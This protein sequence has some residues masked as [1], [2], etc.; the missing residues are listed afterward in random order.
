MN[1]KQISIWTASFLLIS[2]VSFGALQAKEQVSPTK[3]VIN[4]TDSKVNWIGKKPGGEHAGF[5]KLSQGEIL[6]ENNEIKGGSFVIDLNTI[7]NTDLK[8]EGMNARL[9]GHLKSADFF[10][11][12]K[13]ATA[14]F[15]ITKIAKAPGTAAGDAKA[16][17]NIEGDLT[18]KGITKKIRFDASINVLNGKVTASTMPF[19]IDRTLWGVNYQSKS[20]FAELKDQFIYDDIT[21]SI[22]L[23][24]K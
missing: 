21:L 13:Y 20:V 24:T 2:S 7:T 22:D 12:A 19:T 10:D 15:V 1:R 23:V 3:L 14:K 16:T 11:V 6:I 9:V 8:D 4:S 18:I 17:H 5:V